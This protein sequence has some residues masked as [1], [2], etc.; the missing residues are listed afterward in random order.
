MEV[1][2]PPGSTT[3]F[4]SGLPVSLAKPM[5]GNFTY[6]GKIGFHYNG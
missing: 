4:A 1:V 6:G 5:L 3:F 2:E